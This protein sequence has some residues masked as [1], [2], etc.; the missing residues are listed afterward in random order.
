VV[1]LSLG[2]PVIDSLPQHAYPLAILQDEKQISPLITNGFINL[3]ADN[4]NN[5]VAVLDYCE[6]SFLGFA[7]FSEMSYCCTRGDISKTIVEYA[8]ANLEEGYYVFPHVNEYYIPFS[9]AYQHYRL[10]H[11]IMIYGYDSLERIF[12]VAGYNDDFKLSFN[13]VSF[14]DLALSYNRMSEVLRN[15]KEEYLTKLFLL[16]PSHAHSTVDDKLIT[17]SLKD[18]LNSVNTVKEYPRDYDTKCETLFG[19]EVYELLASHYRMAEKQE[20]SLLSKNLY[21][22]SEHKKLM[23]HR[24]KA[25][26][27]RKKLDL[28]EIQDQYTELEKMIKLSLALH[29]KFSLTGAREIASKISLILNKCKRLEES[30]LESLVD[31]I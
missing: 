25:L 24:L 2:Y 21:I 17:A 15:S 23:V 11:G 10:G 1:K 6:D 7:P 29:L 26:A 30:A 27:S 3:K 19:L 12:N 31:I 9:S 18:L 20:I 13:T 28:T 5:H 22:L 16:K 4:Y 14:N 8:I